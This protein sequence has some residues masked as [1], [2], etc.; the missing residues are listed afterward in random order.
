[1]GED[2]TVKADECREQDA[3]VLCDPVSNVVEVGCLLVILGIELEPSGITQGDRILLV[4]PDGE[5]STQC[6]VDD[7]HDN[8][9]AQSCSV[10]THLKHQGKTLRCCCRID[11]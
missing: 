1:M 9:E 8:R 7:G 11:A 2:E 5:R 6:P 10:E 3:L 4:V